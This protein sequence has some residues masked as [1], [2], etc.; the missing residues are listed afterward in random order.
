MAKKNVLIKCRVVHYL[1]CLIK[2][3]VLD[4]TLKGMSS[5]RIENIT[6]LVCDLGP[7]FHT[8]PNGGNLNIETR[9]KHPLTI[10]RTR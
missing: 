5:S 10:Y 8:P 1:N 2:K 4:S 9:T 7:A 3:I 6:N